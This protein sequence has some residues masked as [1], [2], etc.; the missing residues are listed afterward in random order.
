MPLMAEDVFGGD[1]GTL[2]ALLAFMGIGSLIGALGMAR[3]TRPNPRRLMAGAVVMGGVTV[4]AALMPT[5]RAELAALVVLGLASIVFMITGNTTLQLTS[6]PQMRGRV[7]ALYSVVFLGGTPFG[8]PFAGWTAEIL[9]PRWGLA[10]GGAIAVAVGL[11]GLRAVG[12]GTA[13]RLEEVPA[14][15]SAA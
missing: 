2:G 8:A 3:G 14:P 5:L 10:I 12:R 9:G 4:L 15:A 13:A 6:R 1:A 7:M 11:A